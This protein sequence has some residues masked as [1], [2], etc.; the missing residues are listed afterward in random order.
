VLAYIEEPREG[1][2]VQMNRLS[3]ALAVVLALAASAAAQLSTVRVVDASAP[4]GGNGQSWGMAYSSLQLALDE[5]AG[6]GEIAQIWVAAGVY[7][8]TRPRDPADPKSASFALQNGIAILGGFAGNEQ[9]VWERD[10]QINVTVLSGGEGSERVYSVVHAEGVDATAILDG[11]TIRHGYAWG[12]EA[13]AFRGAGLHISGSPRIRDCIIRDNDALQGGGVWTDGEPVFLRCTFI[14]NRAVSG[15]T[16]AHVIGHAQFVE[17]QFI[18]SI[19]D[20]GAGTVFGSGMFADC[21]FQDR[22]GT[23]DRPTATGGAFIRSTFRRTFGVAANALLIDCE[24]VDNQ[25]PEVL[26]FESTLVNCRIEN[27]IG[28]IASGSVFINSLFRGNV[29]LDAL[30]RA[31]LLHDCTMVNCTLLNNAGGNT[32]GAAMIT[33]STITNSILWGNCITHGPCTG[34]GMLGQT[35]VF[36]SL[37]QPASAGLGES[38]NFSADPLF[39]DDMGRLLATS[40]AIDAGNNA[41]LPVWVATDLDGNPRFK[42]DA[43]MPDRGTPGGLGGSAI[44]DLGALEF[45][46]TTCYANCDNS[47]VAPILNVE[48]FICFIQ[49]FANSDPYTDCDGS[50]SLNVEDVI[51]FVGQ[52]AQGCP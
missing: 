39:A 20:P 24:I 52:F 8:P 15:G 5:A 9:F 19:T 47:E 25:F 11:F 28:S 50:G 46:G 29:P 45:Q 44:V 40:P 30:G 34:A 14:G 16:A 41:A 37:L 26:L 51:C 31:T 4:P 21:L 42:D 3:M 33:A 38:G 22:S 17:C 48:D 13:S 49:R 7:I 18:D 6:G 35:S 23:V 27:N 12:Q 32:L 2:G 43:G 10:P 36:T 1:K